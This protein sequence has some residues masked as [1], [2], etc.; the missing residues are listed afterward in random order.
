M[1]INKGFAKRALAFLLCF[2]MLLGVSPLNALAE[3][4]FSRLNISLPEFRLPE[5]N[6]FGTKA[7]A[8]EDEP[9]YSGYCGKVWWF[10]GYNGCFSTDENGNY[11][12][13]DGEQIFPVSNLTWQYDA[14]S[15][16]LSINGEGEMQD[17]SM[18]YPAPWNAYKDE[19]ENIEIADTV[20]S[21]GSCA[22]YDFTAVTEVV[23]PEGIETIGD[24]AFGRS[25]NEYEIGN[26]Y[27]EQEDTQT[28]T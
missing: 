20:T 22:F 15:K 7:S 2:V 6:L 3:V 21:I 19:I 10:E 24:V 18:L 8:D 27:C 1:K 9:V 14:G 5:F 13:E 12:N 26:Y 23:I 11:Y 25:F 16:T 17:Y 28:I 4:D